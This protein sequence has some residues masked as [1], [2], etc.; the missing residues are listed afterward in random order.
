MVKILYGIQGEGMG[1]IMRSKA[2]I[3]DLSKQHEIIVLG[4]HTVCNYFKNYKKHLKSIVKVA[5][6]KLCYHNNSVFTTATFLHNIVNIPHHIY[7]FFKVFF[8]IIKE[9]PNIIITDLEYYS[10]YLGMLFSIPVISIDNQ[11]IITKYRVAFNKKY[12]WNYIKSKLVIRLMVPRADK[13]IITTFFHPLA[14]QSRAV[15]VSPL[16]RSSILKMKPKE[17]NHLLVYQTSS[18]SKEL[19][20]ALQQLQEKCIVYGFNKNEK[21]GNIIFK[22]F[23]EKA[24]FKD[25]ESCKAVIMNGSLTLMTEALYLKKPV[26][27]VPVKRQFEQILN[28]EYLEKKGYGAHEEHFTSTKLKAFI[29]DIPQYRKRLSSPFHSGNHKLSLLLNRIIK[30]LNN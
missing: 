14:K 25:L 16:L 30:D 11:H 27:S 4:S 8:I 23:N 17:G 2:V 12:W 10:A 1:H 21:K 20:P 28:A 6:L 29:M 13:Y 15:I 3:E 7:S 5:Y 19:I 22:T 24:F 26:F 9:K 18:T